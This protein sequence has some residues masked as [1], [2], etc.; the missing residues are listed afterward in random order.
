MQGPLSFEEIKHGL[1][2]D[3][4]ATAQKCLVTSSAAVPAT[5]DTSHEIRFLTVYQSISYIPKEHCSTLFSIGIVWTFPLLT[6]RG[7]QTHMRVKQMTSL[8][9]EE[10]YLG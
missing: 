6:L 5:Q 8:S 4:E 2:E 3:E 9:P 7:R 1:L 10:Q